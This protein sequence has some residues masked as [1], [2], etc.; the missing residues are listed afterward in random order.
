MNSNITQT[1]L[2]QYALKK[3]KKI[4]YL[5]LKKKSQERELLDELEKEIE[6]RLIEFI[7]KIYP[8]L[9]NTKFE[10]EWES[11][12]YILLKGI[13]NILKKM[14]KEHSIGLTASDVK[15]LEDIMKPDKDDSDDDDDKK[16]KKK[17]KKGNKNDSDDKKGGF[18]NLKKNNK[19]NVNENNHILPEKEENVGQKPIIDKNKN[20]QENKNQ[21]NQPNNQQGIINN[22]NSPNNN[23]IQNLK[24]NSN[25]LNPQNKP[26]GII[27][28]PTN[29]TTLKNDEGEKDPARTINNQNGTINNNNSQG[30]S[31]NPEPKK[32]NIPKDK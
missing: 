17:N 25:S 2:T 16:K 23:N 4:L 3:G 14:I 10:N 12:K 19:D 30:N 13:V 1:S 9:L 20:C 22:Q 11:Y 29:S 26:Q 6:T 15:L 7:K 24:G 32:N 21:S 8:K 18:D 5:V 27:N 31:I 28:G